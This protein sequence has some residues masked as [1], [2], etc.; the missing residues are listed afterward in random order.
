MPTV[1][2]LNGFNVRIYTNDHEPA[3][4]HVFKADGEVRIRLGLGGN[5]PKLLEVSRRMSVRDAAQA[6]VMVEE[7]NDFL[8]L[9]WRK[10]HG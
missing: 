8:L 10:I 9:E 4:V 6:V 2:R 1:L 7:H 5:R 3:H